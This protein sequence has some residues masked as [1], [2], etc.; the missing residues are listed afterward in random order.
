MSKEKLFE[1]AEV[2]ISNVDSHSVEISDSEGKVIAYSGPEKE[3]NRFYDSFSDI[4]R[5]ENAINFDPGVMKEMLFKKDNTKIQ[6]LNISVTSDLLESADKIEE[7]IKNEAKKGS[8]LIVWV[9]GS[10]ELS[11]LESFMQQ[12]NNIKSQDAD[13]GVTLAY[14]NDPEQSRVECILL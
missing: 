5:K 2:F 10:F 6:Y 1:N 14:A 7:F 8:G 12:I 4:C 11:S 9:R 3:C 13:L